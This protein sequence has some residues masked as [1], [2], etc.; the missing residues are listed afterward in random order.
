M[1]KKRREERVVK[2]ETFASKQQHQKKKNTLMAL[3]VLAIVASI[4]V[5]A[6]YIF[7]TTEGTAIG[8]PPNAGSLGDEHEHASMLTMIHGDRFDYAS[9]AFQVKTTWIHFERQDGATVHRHASGVDLAYLFNSLSIG[10]DKECFIFPDGK[11][12]C[13]NDDYSLKF[14]MNHKLVP[15]ITEYVIQDNDRILI[16]Y[17][18]DTEEQINEQLTLLDAQ[19]ILS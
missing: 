5:Y 11:Q 2:R 15:D 12:F 14:Y 8:A 16:S 1:G 10:L 7:V 13:T 3:G 4:V 6:S 19:P 9:P 18:G 17:G